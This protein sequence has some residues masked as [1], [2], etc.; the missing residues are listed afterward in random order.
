MQAWCPCLGIRGRGSEPR[1]RSRHS[2]ASGWAALHRP[3]VRPRME[4]PGRRHGVLAFYPLT[5]APHLSDA[6]PPPRRLVDENADEAAGD[7]VG[8]QSS[9]GARI[10]GRVTPIGHK[11]KRVEDV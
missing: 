6:G 3:A 10:R 11:N 2:A 4:E 1:R 8:F 5:A 9:L 7:N